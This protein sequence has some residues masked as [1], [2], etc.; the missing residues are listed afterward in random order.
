LERIS[1][2]T[3][4]HRS[5]I[6]IGE[7]WTSF[8]N[9]IPRADTVI[10]TDDNIYGLYGKDFPG[11][12]VISI[13]PGE[14][15]KNLAVIDGLVRKLL[16]IGIGRNGFLVG[17]GGGVV[18]DI[19]GF[20]A[21]VYMRGIGFGFVSTSLL[22]QID[23]SIGGKN[24]VNAGEVKN[25]IGTFNQPEFVICDP[26][27]LKTLPDDEF[28]SGMAEL[29]KAGFILDETLINEIEK[30]PEPLSKREPFL[31][32]KLITMSVEIKAAIVARDEKET[33]IRKILNFGHT[34][35][36]AIEA[37]TGLKHGF[38]VAAGMII[39]ADISVQLGILQQEER[40]RLFNLLNTLKLLVKYN[41]TTDQIKEL[42]SLD[43]KKSGEAVNFI[44]L[45]KT[46]K[47]FVK[48][49]TIAQLLDSYQLLNN[50]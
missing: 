16:E 22:S 46:G 29:V 6:L 32:T 41:V 38:A 24:G 11:F 31:L 40:N 47:A 30:N 9:Y 43:K 48:S 42:I 13:P 19:T 5:E 14:K 1:I 50:R 37:E 33:G 8:G 15:S 3:N 21:S 35:G 10:I 17:I 25:I 23:A 39:A 18:C 2:N 36:H 12:P 45:E 26:E 27:M 7:K 34:F 4:C 28:L 20:L 49:I 44:L